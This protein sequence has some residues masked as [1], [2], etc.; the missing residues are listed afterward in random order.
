MHKLSWHQ[1]KVP[2]GAKRTYLRPNAIDEQ[3]ISKMREWNG[4]RANAETER[5]IK[6]AL[7]R[8]EEKQTQ[9]G[10]HF[11]VQ[12]HFV[13][14]GFLAGVKNGTIFIEGKKSAFNPKKHPHIQLL[15]ISH[16]Q[17]YYSSVSIYGYKC[18]CVLDVRS[19]LV[20]IELIYTNL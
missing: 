12:W 3:H 10:R 8:K 14:S 1:T 7:I 18:I 17:T 16:S 13:C 11:S 20:S 15:C 2:L 9:T 5:D 6:L 4:C 19:R